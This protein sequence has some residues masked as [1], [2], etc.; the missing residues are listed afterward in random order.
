VHP[1]D[2]ARVEAVLHHSLAVQ[3]DFSA[4][5]RVVRPDGTIRWMNGRGHTFY[6]AAG[7][8]VRMVGLM[9]DITDHKQTEAALRS[10]NATLEQRVAERTTALQREMAE[11][12]QMQATLFQHEKLAAM[13]SLLA[14]VAHELNNPLSIILLHA[15]L[16][17]TDASAGPLA[18]YTVEITQAARR[19]ERLVRQFLTLARQQAP[20]WAEVDLN[21]LLTTVLELLTPSLRVDNIAVEL[22][23]DEALPRLW[24]DPHQLQ[25]VVVNL[26]TNA[27]QALRDVTAPRQLTLT[28]GYDPVRRWITLKVTDTGL[29]MSPA[30]QARIFE[31]FFTTKAPG[32]GTGLGLPL[33]RSILENHGGTLRCT[34]APGQGTTFQ[35]ELPVRSIPETA[36]AATTEESAPP[37]DPSVILLVDD[38][39][40]ITN[41]L[42]RL[43]RR[44]GH[45]VDTATNGRLA[46]LKLQER[47]YDLI[48]SDLRMPELDGPGLY[49]ALAALYPQLRQRFILLTGDTLNPDTQA[50]SVQHGVPH[51]TKPYTAAEIR[52]VIR[53]VLQAG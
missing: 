29:G 41:A 8:P 36:S 18:D 39:P 9:L 38:E 53:Q 21:T 17:Q 26:V 47:A 19:C 32:I 40:S 1:E 34:S 27:Q 11:R 5:Y 20:E 4:E 45:T 28:T 43:L 10:L 30:I 35:I 7:E 23:L 33:C 6:N 49:R 3:R 52:R 12:Q 14:S 2:I 16:L 51:L 31:P 44:D 37:P 24:A 13:G 42:T 48:L 50:F 46:L 22:Y 15:D 25:Q